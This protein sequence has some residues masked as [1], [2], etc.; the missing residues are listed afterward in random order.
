MPKNEGSITLR[1]EISRNPV[2]I[3]PAFS[4]NGLLYCNKAEVVT[5]LGS[6]DSDSHI[7]PGS[8]NSMPLCKIVAMLNTCVLLFQE[9]YSKPKPGQF[10][11]TLGITP[12]KADGLCGRMI[13]DRGA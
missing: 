6:A 1:I 8:K 11:T 13:Y 12:N 4:W 10:S 3:A 5:A 2:L 9:L 7:L